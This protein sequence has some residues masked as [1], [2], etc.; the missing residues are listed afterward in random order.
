[1]KVLGKVG[2]AALA[3]ALAGLIQAV[4][5]AAPR[6]APAAGRW[7]HESSDLAVDPR[8]RYGVLPN[9]MRYALMK[10]GTPPGEASLRLHIGAGSLAEQDDQSGLAHF[11]EHMVL[12]G[13]RNVPEGDFVRRLE[14]HGLRFGPDT[15]ASTSF[16]RTLYMLELP[17]T[18]AATVDTALFLLREVAGEATLD[19]AAIESERGI[20]LSEERSRASPGQRIFEDEIAF[21]L[22]G[23]LLP[24]RIPIGTT[25][26]IRT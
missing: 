23:D 25:E 20:I 18:D 11:L 2:L 13:T 22:K 4:G 12:N 17:E 5:L 21:M 6:A 10:N 9:G 26:V 7:A 14:R 16:D 19:S 15:N 24:R 8:I 1:M 3:L